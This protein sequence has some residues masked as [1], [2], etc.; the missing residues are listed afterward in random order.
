MTSA[1]T[2][3]DMPELMWT[4]VPPAKSSAPHVP[5]TMP[6]PHTMWA[7]G[8]Y[9]SVAQSREKTTNALNFMRSANAPVMSAGVM[10]ANIIWYAMY[11]WCG[12]V[13]ASGAGS[14]PTPRSPRCARPPITPCTSG[15]NAKL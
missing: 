3:A 13:G 5:P 12:M 7:S 10:T 14:T 2:S 6:P 11:S 1:H 9:T 15:P 8:S 4:T